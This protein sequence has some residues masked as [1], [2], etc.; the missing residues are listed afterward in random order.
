MNIILS[1]LISIITLTQDCPIKSL[2]KTLDGEYDVGGALIE[3]FN[4]KEYSIQHICT[5]RAHKIVLQRFIR[6]ADGGQVVWEKRAEL[7]IP[8]GN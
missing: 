8:T 5:L 7:L 3:T 6:Y 2:P 4:E 1:I